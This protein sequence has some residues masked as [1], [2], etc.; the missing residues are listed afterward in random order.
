MMEVFLASFHSL[1]IFSSSRYSWLVV[2]RNSGLVPT[3]RVSLSFQ[4]YSG[5]VFPV[6]V[7]TQHTVHCKIRVLSADFLSVHS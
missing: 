5:L 7:R 6:K 1:R 4:V 3:G 2:P